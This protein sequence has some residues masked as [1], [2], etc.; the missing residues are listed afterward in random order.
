M[1]SV[2]GNG[3]IRKDQT[4][5][6]GRIKNGGGG[7]GAT[8]DDFEDSDTVEFIE[9][10]DGKVSANV[11]PNKTFYKKVILNISEGEPPYE[12]VI[13]LEDAVELA[14]HYLNGEYIIIRAVE[15]EDSEYNIL[16]SLQSVYDETLSSDIK[17]LTMTFKSMYSEE[18]VNQVLLD[19]ALSTE[20]GEEEFTE[21]QSIMMEIPATPTSDDFADSD[22]IVWSEDEEGFPKADLDADITNKISRALV[23]PT[24]SPT[25]I[26]LVGI[27]DNNSQA[28]I[29]LDSNTLE[30]DNGVLKVKGNGFN[31]VIVKKNELIHTN[32]STLYTLGNTGYANVQLEPGGSTWYCP[33]PEGFSKVMFYGKN[34]T[35][36]GN[37]FYVG[38]FSAVEITSVLGTTKG[39]CKS[40]LKSS[41]DYG[42]VIA[43]FDITSGTDNYAVIRDGWMTSQ[44]TDVY[45]LFF[46]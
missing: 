13:S 40:N 14:N 3:K 5:H 38:L 12:N 11:D 16:Y 26:E 24:T 18:S 31:G 21:V 17:Q 2:L 42:E 45:I 9:T 33:I 7:G 6:Y 39:F 29:T 34:N 4:D 15:T 8:I 30:V 35:T 27:D 25:E 19:I 32:A 22:S 43:K 28:R 23:T 20:E 36:T 1:S 46:N 10:A 41:L 37:N 44:D